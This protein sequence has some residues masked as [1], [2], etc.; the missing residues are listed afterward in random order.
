MFR[1]EPTGTRLKSDLIRHFPLTLF[2]SIMGLAGLTLAWMQA[3]RLGMIG[4]PETADVLRLVSSAVYGLLLLFYG[5]KLLLFPQQVLADTRHPVRLNYLAAIP[6]AML[7]LATSWYRD[8]PELA[9]L[10]WWAAALS[11]LGVTIYTMSSWIHHTHYEVTH[12]NPAW[13]IPVVGNAI[14]PIAGVHL[15]PHDLCWFFFSIGIVFWLVVMT[16]VMYRLFFHAPLPERI[17]PTLFIM[18][19]P[20]A[21]AFN[22]YVA[23]TGSVDGFARVLYFVSLFLTIVLASN[24]LRFLRLPFFI[25]GW[26]YSF[27]LAALT[28]ATM[29]MAARSG[30]AFYIGLSWALLAAIS[31]IV[32]WLT[33]K[34]LAAAV[35]GTLC[36]AEN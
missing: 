11:L 28:L 15:A 4:S 25:S 18:V 12:V 2:T 31:A 17:T 16:I 19:A 22:A 32:A 1:P 27:P 14:A 30:A 29:E 26:A 35:H 21:V 5:L 23:L 10:F 13:F 7:L 9:A 36:V 3:Q 20:P 24:F 6:I 33:Y 8:W 34:T